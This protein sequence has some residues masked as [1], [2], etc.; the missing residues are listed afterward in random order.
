MPALEP[1]AAD[2]ALLDVAREA[3]AHAY[4]P[5]SRYLVG[6]AIRSVDGAVV[7][8]ANVENIVLPEGS[9]AEKVALYA[10]VAQGHRKF[11][12][13]AVF[14]ESDP[15]ALPCGSC[16]QILNHWGI[17]RVVFGNTAG[18]VRVLAMSELLPYAFA[19]RDPPE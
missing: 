7:P 9:C 3:R 10:A 12:A 1:E 17:E 15:P 5:I 2:L 14:T 4:A 8:G 13:V 19:L 11:D 16:R 6:A 18:V